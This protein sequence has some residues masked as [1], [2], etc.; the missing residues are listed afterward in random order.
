[1]NASLKIRFGN[2]LVERMLKITPS[3]AELWALARLGARHLLHGS[4]SEAV[5]PEIAA[6]WAEAVLKMDVGD[7]LQ[8]IFVLGQIAG[9]TEQRELKLSQASLEK[10]VAH[11]S[12]SPYS[13]ALRKALF[14]LNPWTSLEQEKVYGDGLPLGISLNR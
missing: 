2:L 12:E 1:M 8:K 11:F 4:L 14:E 9:A 5:P 7:P 13:E 3:P 10:I 6:D